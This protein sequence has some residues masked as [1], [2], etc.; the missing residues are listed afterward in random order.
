MGMDF[1]ISVSGLDHFFGEG[2]AR[3]QA[4]WDLNLNIERGSLTTLMGPSG[5]GKQLC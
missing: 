1:P 4:I 2:E 3:K 5:S